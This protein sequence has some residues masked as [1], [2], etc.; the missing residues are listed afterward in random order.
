MMTV[1][2][3]W[4]TIPLTGYWF[5]LLFISSDATFRV[6]VPAILVTIELWP[7][8]A[9][10][11]PSNQPTTMEALTVSSTAFSNN[12]GQWSLTATLNAITQIKE[13]KRDGWPQSKH[14]IL[15]P[16]KKEAMLSSN[17]SFSKAVKGWT[18]MEEAGGGPKPACRRGLAES[19]PAPSL[20]RYSLESTTELHTTQTNM[21][22]HAPVPAQTLSPISQTSQSL[23]VLFMAAMIWVF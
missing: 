18:R 9:H 10:H 5:H 7:I 16:H 20:C 13:N 23:S 8:L 11:P 1:F 19:G 17:L 6:S 3:F 12:G 22:T 14:L 2:F 21:S 4:R 15:E